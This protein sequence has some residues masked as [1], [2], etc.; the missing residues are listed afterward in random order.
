MTVWF[1]TSLWLLVG[2]NGR[3]PMASL[4]LRSGVEKTG[5]ATREWKRAVEEHRGSSL[6]WTT[7][8]LTTDEVAWRDTIRARLVDWESRI[9]SLMLPFDGQ[10]PIR[11]VRIVL[12]NQNGE[13]AFGVGGDTFYLDLAAL[14]RTYGPAAAAGNRER[15]DRIF[16]HECTHVLQNRWEATHAF[17]VATPYDRALRQVWREGLGNM[18]SLSDE[19]VTSSGD[20]TPRAQNALEELAPILVDRLRRLRVAAE[21]DEGELC[22]GFRPA[23]SRRSGAP[24][25]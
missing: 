23:P 25:R 8:P 15:L 10:R 22:M 20:L 4:D 7:R 1:A 16:A 3:P 18:Y 21:S 19:W 12:G 2:S 9:P 14:S 13:D 11:K 6:N 24:C 5:S 17:R